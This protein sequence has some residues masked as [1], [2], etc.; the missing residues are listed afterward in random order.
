MKKGLLILFL[1]LSWSLSAQHETLLGNVNSISGFGG[2][3]V[4]IGSING[5]VG[6]DV[7]GGGAIIF[8][9]LFLGGY[10]LG[11]S[12]PETRIDDE[13]YEIRFKHGGFWLGYVSNP[14]KM[15]HLYSSLRLGWGKAQLRQDKDPIY[16]DRLFAMTPELGVEINLTRFMKLGVSGG[17]RW[18]NG[19]NLQT[20]DSGD[21][22]SPVGLL[23]FRF[24]SFDENWDLDVDGW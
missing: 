9:K 23:T 18:V 15:V 3:L 16:S 6:A 8:D 19:V 4:E 1:G 17:Y 2:P 12:Y 21:F 22:S 5:D 7:G 13:L 10:G 14:Y 20:L 11:S 24:G